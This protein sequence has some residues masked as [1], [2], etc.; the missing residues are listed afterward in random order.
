[1]IAK[2]TSQLIRSPDSESL[3]LSFDFRVREGDWLHVFVHQLQ[4]KLAKEVIVK[5][6]ILQSSVDDLWLPAAS[7]QLKRKEQSRVVFF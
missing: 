6:N 2:K 1:M 5:F 4:I 3:E 7:V